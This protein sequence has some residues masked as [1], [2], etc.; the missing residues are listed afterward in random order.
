M[1]MARAGERLSADAYTRDSVEAY[2]RAVADER[3]RLELAIAEEHS[4][5]EAAGQ[6][7]GRLDA[8]APAVRPAEHDV[9]PDRPV[10][11]GE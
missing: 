3:T 7:L 8:A 6:L 10:A 11:S 2:L 4:R 9:I 1:F 5:R